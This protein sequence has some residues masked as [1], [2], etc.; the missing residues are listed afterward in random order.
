MRSN[1]MKKADLDLHLQ[2]HSGGESEKNDDSGTYWACEHDNSWNID[3]IFFYL[4][5]SLV[6]LRIMS[7]M[8]DTDL[9]LQGYN[10]VKFQL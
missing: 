10:V 1:H 2:S 6:F 8:G 5:H 3:T 7:E 4:L 9:H